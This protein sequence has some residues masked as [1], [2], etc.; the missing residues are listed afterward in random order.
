ML[1]WFNVYIT[2][3]KLSLK[4][5]RFL[6]QENLSLKNSKEELNVQLQQ[7][8]FFGA[9]QVGVNEYVIFLIVSI[10]FL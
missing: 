1:L 8:G 10:W 4:K 7:D 3:I 2:S 5:V 6:F 9:E